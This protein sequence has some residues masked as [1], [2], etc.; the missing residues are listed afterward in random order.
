MRGREG[1]KI[2]KRGG[3]RREGVR[4]VEKGGKGRLVI[5]HQKEGRN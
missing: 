1:G 3:E 2:I 4:C 5:S